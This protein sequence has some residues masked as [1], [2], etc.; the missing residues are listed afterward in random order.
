MALRPRPRQRAACSSRA[1]PV[2]TKRAGGGG[3]GKG[4]RGGG[5]GRRGGRGGREEEEEEENALFHQASLRV[6]PEPVLVNLLFWPTSHTI[7][8]RKKST[9]RAS[10]SSY[11][12]VLREKLRQATTRLSLPRIL[13]TNCINLFG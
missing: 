4:G 3:G 6:C 1:S 9:E 10:F 5:G 13:R 8:R 2:G 12:A 11:R 7:Q